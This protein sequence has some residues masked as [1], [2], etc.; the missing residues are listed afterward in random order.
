[1][2]GCSVPNRLPAA[3]VCPHP[4]ALLLLLLPFL[5]LLLQG[6]P[7]CSPQRISSQSGGQKSWTSPET[8]FWQCLWDM[9]WVG[10]SHF[11]AHPSI[12][13]AGTGIM[14]RAA[15]LGIEPCKV[16]HGEEMPCQVSW[17]LPPFLHGLLLSSS[18]LE[19]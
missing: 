4:A 18:S 3:D 14:G 15:E 13:M 9:S 12:G 17:P 7:V 10:W 16:E 19:K 8:G 11:Q 2:R 6:T 5:F 1:M